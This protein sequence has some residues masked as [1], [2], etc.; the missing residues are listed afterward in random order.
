MTGGAVTLEALTLKAPRAPTRREISCRSH[1][2][3]RHAPIQRHR[4]RAVQLWGLDSGD[5]ARE[6]FLRSFAREN[7]LDLRHTEGPAINAHRI[8]IAIEIGVATANSGRTQ[9]TSVILRALP[10]I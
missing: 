8:E 7:A 9:I 2:R 6:G 4:R 3:R 10:Q 1:A 5:N